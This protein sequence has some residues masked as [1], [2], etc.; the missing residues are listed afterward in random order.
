MLSL[1]MRVVMIGAVI[2]VS[3]PISLLS[4]GT[5]GGLSWTA[6]Q[7]WTPLTKPMRAANYHVAPVA[8]DSDA[9]E[10]GVYFFGPG[11]G[12]STD[13]NVKRWIGQ[14]RTADGKPADGLAKISTRTVKGIKITFVD[15]IGTHLFKP[16]P[17]ARQATPKPGY[18]L[19]GAI[20]E[21]PEA[22]I[23]F[24]LVGPQ[25]TVTESEADFQGML[26]SLRS[27]K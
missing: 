16:F 18:R 19:I 25:K 1:R 9:A 13:A 11:Q 21:G 4:A 24:K 23:F 3:L 27:A 5:A 2:V 15:I 12:G 7:K 17:M 20:A 26:D 6:P 22:P 14:F 8:G 10:C